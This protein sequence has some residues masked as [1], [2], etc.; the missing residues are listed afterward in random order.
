MVRWWY[1]RRMRP[2]TAASVK[3]AP[4]SLPPD[5]TTPDSTAAE[6]PVEGQGYLLGQPGRLATGGQLGGHH[7]TMRT[8]SARLRRTRSRRRNDRSAVAALHF[9]KPPYQVDAAT[10]GALVKVARPVVH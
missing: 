3:A 8:E 5:G 7:S 6:H 10:P 2:T 4:A 1:S 9:T